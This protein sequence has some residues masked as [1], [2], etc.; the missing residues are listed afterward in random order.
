MSKSTVK[1]IIVVGG[2]FGG[3]NCARELARNK[4]LD[5]LILD[6]R[7]HHLFQP[8]LYQVA[9]AGLSPADIST[10]I[11][12]VFRK[13]KNV[14]VLMAE[15]S[16]ISVSA[17]KVSTSVGEFKFDY[18]VL[19][20]GAEH[21]YFGH[22][23][24]ED[25]A[26]GLKTLEQA[27][28]IRRRVLTAFEKAEAQPDRE[29]LR[30]WLTFVVV[31]GGPTGV[32]LAGA[33]GEITRY[34][35]TKDFRHID[36]ADARIILVEAGPKI[37]APFY[38]ELGKKARRDLE[39]L[40]VHITTNT[41]VSEVTSEGVR[42]GSEW[43]AAKTVIWAA[44]VKPSP[45]SSQLGCALDKAGR[46]VVND[47]CSLPNA[48]NIFVLGDQAHFP[49]AD[50]R[51]LAGLAPVAIQQGRFVGKL[52]AHDQQGTR[53]KFRYVDK[54]TMATIGRRKA[55]A[56]IGKLRVSGRVAWYMWLLIHIYFLIGFKNRIFVLWQWFYSYVTYKRGARLITQRDW[57]L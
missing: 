22:N 10:P 53:P 38:D 12:S 51:G 36:P 40:G 54:G 17:K 27:T 50:G 25:F 44:G 30:Q 24:W 26:P 4:N 5:I 35:L 42:M 14:R 52:I 6:R 47:D 41:V 23:E 18:L 43:V 9:M 55:V 11:R 48:P 46:A 49:T 57:H 37:L 3:L 16:E 31:G 20:C 56:Q 32:E 2:G 34:T 28:E 21:S 1:K 33:L 15:V 29:K 39:E 7:N 13:Q 45:L 19:A 8:L